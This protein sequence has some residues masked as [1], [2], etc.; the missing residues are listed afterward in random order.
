MRFISER[1]SI[2]RDLSTLG[3]LGGLTKV[4]ADRGER[5]LSLAGDGYRAAL[6]H[7]GALTRLNELGL[8]AQVRTVGAVSGGSIVA[9]LLATKVPWPLHGAYRGWP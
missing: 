3:K 6:F 8:L 9:A 4:E 7:L 2:S 5:A 1:R